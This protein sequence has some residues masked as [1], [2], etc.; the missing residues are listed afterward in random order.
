MPQSSGARSIKPLK[1]AAGGCGGCG[2]TADPNLVAM[3][4]QSL[5]IWPTQREG[6]R[7][8]GPTK[9]LCPNPF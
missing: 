3:G 9:C 1:V 8:N 6:L 5:V 2:L 4:I 7:K